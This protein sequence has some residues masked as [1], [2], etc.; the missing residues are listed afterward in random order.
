M[1]QQLDA[2]H[3]CHL[4]VSQCQIEA[5][6]LCEFDRSFARSG[7]GDVVAFTRQ[8]HFQNF[9]LWLVVVDNQNTFPRHVS[10]DERQRMKLSPTRFSSVHPP[11]FIL[12]PF[13]CSAGNETLNVVPLPG[14]DSTLIS[15]P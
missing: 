15:P 2:I 5:S 12:H 11:S 7:G 6:L 8:N 1:L 9:P 4:Q 14:F 3:P 13:F 10:K